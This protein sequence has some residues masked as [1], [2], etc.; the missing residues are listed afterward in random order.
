M[1]S[2]WDHL[3]TPLRQRFTKNGTKV[4]Y[5]VRLDYPQFAFVAACAVWFW[6]CQSLWWEC[7]CFRSKG[8]FQ[9]SGLYEWCLGYANIPR[10]PPILRRRTVCSLWLLLSTWQWTWTSLHSWHRWEQSTAFES[11]RIWKK[12]KYL[13]CWL[14]IVQIHFI[15]AYWVESKAFTMDEFVWDIPYLNRKIC[16][17]HC[18]IFT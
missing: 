12:G 2:F 9:V 18:Q 1:D 14:F 11:P 13:V 15:G 7:A 17:Y 3:P 5:L 8:Y 10:Q 6:H 4:S 16:L